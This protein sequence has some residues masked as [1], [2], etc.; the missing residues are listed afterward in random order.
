MDTATVLRQL[1]NNSGPHPSNLPDGHPCAEGSISMLERLMDESHIQPVADDGDLDDILCAYETPELSEA[2]R[3]ESAYQSFD[4]SNSNPIQGPCVE[5]SN[6]SE[7]WE[8]AKTPGCPYIAVKATGSPSSEKTIAADPATEPVPWETICES[9]AGS[10]PF[11]APASGAVSASCADSKPCTCIFHEPS[12][13]VAELLESGCWEHPFGAEGE[14]QVPEVPYQ[15]ESSAP[16]P[17]TCTMPMPG[18]ND[19]DW[20]PNYLDWT[21]VVPPS[22]NLPVAPGKGE[23]RDDWDFSETRDMEGVDESVKERYKEGM[24]GFLRL[25]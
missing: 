16:Y 25:N 15:P 13:T 12:T 3:F 24:K 14:E 2:E 4:S 20:M 11:C 10:C 1:I 7:Y 22:E 23:K 5:Y 9:P 17:E 18:S 6:M 21:P 8:A 19:L